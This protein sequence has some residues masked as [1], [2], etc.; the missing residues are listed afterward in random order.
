MSIPSKLHA[1]LL[2]MLQF[3]LA[4]FIGGFGY[5]YLADLG[6][7]KALNLIAVIVAVIGV[8]FA[9]S[10]LGRVVPVRCKGCNSSSRFLGSGWWPFTYRYRCSRCGHVMKYEIQ[11]G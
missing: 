4:I 7:P 2:F 10:F 11:G 9:A 5:S 6:V 3:M 8:L 1:G